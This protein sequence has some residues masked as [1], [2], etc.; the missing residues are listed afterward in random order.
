[1]DSEAKEIYRG[2]GQEIVQGAQSEV[3]A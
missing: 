2:Q 1:V 3:T